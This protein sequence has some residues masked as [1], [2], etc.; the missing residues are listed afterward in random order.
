MRKL[1]RKEIAGRSPGRAAVVV[2]DGILAGDGVAARIKKDLLDGFNLHTI[3]RLP[4]GVF[5]PYTDI[6]TNVL[7]F[8]YGGAYM[9]AKRLYGNGGTRTPKWVAI[10]GV[11]PGDLRI[12]CGTASVAPR[13]IDR[14]ASGLVC[15]TASRGGALAVRV[16]DPPG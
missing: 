2:P 9:C 8:E 3:V 6:P 13:P 1:R 11:A 4:S 12:G 10:A 15:A 7:F 5:A 14:S 16:R